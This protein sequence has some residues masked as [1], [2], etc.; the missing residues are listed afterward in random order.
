VITDLGILRPDDTG[1]LVLTAT[2]PGVTVDDAVAATG[3]P[4]RVVADVTTTEPPTA[5]ELA[6][7]AE[8]RAA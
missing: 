4:L 6:G 7:L 1:D 8:L 2:H 5:N 3:W